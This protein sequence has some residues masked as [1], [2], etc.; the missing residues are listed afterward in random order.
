MK[1]KVKSGSSVS[2]VSFAWIPVLLLTWW[3]FSETPEFNFLIWD[4]DKYI[5]ENPSLVKS[6]LKE[7][8]TTPVAGNYHPLTMLSL[9][10]NVQSGGVKPASFHVWN[11]LLHLG[12]T[13]LLYFLILSMGGNIRVAFA[14]SL[15][16]GIHPLHVESVAWISERKDVLYTFFLLASWISWR[17]FR[18]GGNILFYILSLILGIASCLSKGMAVVLPLLL[19]LDMYFLEKKRDLKSLLSLIPYFI[20]AGIFAWLAVWAQGTVGAIRQSTDYSLLDKIIFPFYGLVFYP[21]KMILPL[22]LSAVY[23]YPVK[24]V[25]EV[26]PWQYLISPLLVAGIALW[27]WFKRNHTWLVFSSLG[28]VLCIL[29][30]LQILPVG[31]ALTAD[32]YFYVSSLSIC[33]GLFMGLD[34]WVSRKNVKLAGV[35]CLIPLLYIWPAKKRTEVWRDTLSLFSDVVQ[36]YPEVAVAH[37]NMGIVQMN[38]RQNYQAASEAFRKSISV[39]PGYT[40]AYV[41]LGVCLQYMNQYPESVEALMRAIQQQPEHVEA[42]NNLGVAYEKLG[43]TD[44]SLYHY[45]QALGLNPGKVELYNNVGFAYEAMGRLDSAEYYYRRALEIKPG[46]D[47]ALV[48]MGNT[49]LKQGRA[50]SEAEPYFREA[51]RLGHAGAR[52]YL[53]ARGE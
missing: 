1:S 19:F 17:Y 24:A 40:D 2:L 39:R 43:Q 11:M 30:V 10:W 7:I 26:L 41:N 37:Y 38:E 16:F 46:Y 50:W 22:N 8:C 29:P 52:Q 49:I 15:L 5:T 45:R 20:L 33:I 28:Y 48:N 32:R 42:H 25:S 27:V 23:P 34:A 36:K 18:R 31:N 53:Q 44:R 9:K 14:G 4:D 6:S 13:G 21:V 3:V 47:V 35:I 51:A 12:N